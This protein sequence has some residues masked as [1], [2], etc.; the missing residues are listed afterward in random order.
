MGLMNR[1]LHMLLVA[2]WLLSAASSRGGSPAAPVTSDG[3]SA[4]FACDARQSVLADFDRNGVPDQIGP[5]G[6]SGADALR[7]VINGQPSV[8]P[9][10]TSTCR[11]GLFDV[12]RDR[13][14]D[15][16]V[17]DAQGALRVWRNDSG[18]LH[19]LEPDTGLHQTFDQP[20]W[21]D[22]GPVAITVALLPG[23]SPSVV[24]AQ[25]AI[26]S[27]PRDATS[28]AVQ[29]PSRIPL[30]RPLARPPPQR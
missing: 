27:A 18:A 26:P 16:V 5:S 29:P 3:Q 28:Q 11:L 25:Y 2:G 17:L 24:S 14:D 19:R 22:A 9:D 20:T 4:L 21:R 23:F 30:E 15:L 1:V 13:D 12:D 6:D 10:S 8:L 7:L